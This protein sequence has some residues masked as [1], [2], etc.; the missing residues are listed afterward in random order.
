MAKLHTVYKITSLVNSK[1]Y[2]GVHSTND[3]DDGY[4]GS[5]NLIKAAIQKYGPQSFEK[6]I[7]FTYNTREEALKKEAELVNLETVNN[8]LC[9]NMTIGGGG[10]ICLSRTKFNEDY[11]YVFKVN[12]S[13]YQSWQRNIDRLITLNE[14]STDPQVRDINEVQKALKPNIREIWEHLLNTL[15]ETYNYKSTHA[16]ALSTL[17]MIANKNLLDCLYAEEVFWINNEETANA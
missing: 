5:G 10:V 17:K 9:Y 15:T 12:E 11:K 8:P 3:A 16:K 6:E 14:N 2:I 4:M 1:F 13:G 7:L